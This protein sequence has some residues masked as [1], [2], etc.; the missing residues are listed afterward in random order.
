MTASMPD[1]NAP[2]PCAQPSE[3]KRILV[4]DDDDV[5]LLS[6]RRILEKSGYIV[7]THS[8][9]QAALERLPEFWPQ[10]LLVDLKMPELNGFQVMEKVRQL[11]EDIVVVVITGYATIATAVDAM[12]AGAYDFLP[13]PFTP[14]EL[15]LIIGRSHERWRLAAGMRRLERE[16]ADAQRRFVTFV[17]HQLKTPLSAVKQYVDVLLRTQKDGLS[18]TALDWIGKS[19]I[20]LEE[21][22]A[23]IDDWLT[24]AR[25]EDGGLAA[26]TSATDLG[27]I[28]PSLA[29]SARAA[30]EAAQ[31]TLRVE[32]PPSL[33]PVCG[34]SIAVSMVA[35][36]LIHNA[37]KYN[38][39]GGSVTI[40]AALTERCVCL[41]IQ[42]TGI[43]IPEVGLEKLFQEFYRV[44][45]PE[46]RDIPGTGLG[47]A[48]CKRIV[49]ELHGT[50]EVQSKLGQGTTFTVRL[51]TADLGRTSGEAPPDS[52]TSPTPG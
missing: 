29:D 19:K 28:L 31:V 1:P 8:R 39:P 34:D 38:R 47:L 12:K 9:G 30:A 23:L 37:I 11:N 21:M 25:V 49:T 4:V 45:M 2:M 42:D 7:E 44:R 52:K 27:S 26:A 5:I 13:K 36:N 50:I 6:C 51:P 14:D 18:P 24:L 35:S 17:S 41:S 40:A 22:F 10:I 43:G 33:P 15:R 16:K 20:R 48:I 3:E 32:M 46:T